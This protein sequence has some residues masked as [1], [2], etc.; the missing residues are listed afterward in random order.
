MQINLL[1]FS[2]IVATRSIITT[3]RHLAVVR[4]VSIRWRAPRKRDAAID[5][6]EPAPVW[7]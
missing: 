6:V 5:R 7:S 4:A 2:E 3:V 1:D